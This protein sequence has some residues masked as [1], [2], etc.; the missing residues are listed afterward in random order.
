MFKSFLLVIRD[1][2]TTAKITSD[3]Y[4]YSYMGSFQMLGYYQKSNSAINEWI[5]GDRGK[6]LRQNLILLPFTMSPII[7]L[8]QSFCDN[9]SSDD[10]EDDI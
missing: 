6:D 4:L 8:W 9:V 1:Y 2:L 5:K 7:A 10:A 3:L